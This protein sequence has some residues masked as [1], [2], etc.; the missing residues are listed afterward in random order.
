[1][2]SVYRDLE[3]RKSRAVTARAGRGGVYHLAHDYQWPCTRTQATLGVHTATHVRA[4]AKRRTAAAAGAGASGSSGTPAAVSLLVM[5]GAWQSEKGS[6][7]R[8]AREPAQPIRVMMGVAAAKSASEAS[9]AEASRAGG[10]EGRDWERRGWRDGGSKTTG[11]ATLAAVPAAA[12]CSATDLKTEPATEGRHGH[13]PVATLDHHRVPVKRINQKTNTDP[14]S[15]RVG[16]KRGGGKA[17]SHTKGQDGP[18]A[19]RSI[20]ASKDREGHVPGAGGVAV[21]KGG[22]RAPRSC[23]GGGPPPN[24]SLW[25]ALAPPEQL[26]PSLGGPG[27]RGQR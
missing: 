8:A 13:F 15:A 4:D 2:G 5:M 20:D 12:V 25:R 14:V 23:P 7:G 1:M 19:R 27:V 26:Q 22:H 6:R 9:S 3:R 21:D 24:G 17:R 16:A 18:T 11:G 10:Q